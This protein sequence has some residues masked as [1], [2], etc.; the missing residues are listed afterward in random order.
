MLTV[1]LSEGSFSPLACSMSLEAVTN[2]YKYLSGDAMR[3]L[4]ISR[5]APA[6]RLW[7]HT[8]A[9]A[10]LN[11]QDTLH[12]GHLMII[13]KKYQSSPLFLASKKQACNFSQGF[14]VVFGFFLF[15]C[16]FLLGFFGWFFWVFLQ[17][18]TVLQDLFTLCNFYSVIDKNI[19]FTCCKV[20]KSVYDVQQKDVHRLVAF[21]HPGHKGSHSNPDWLLNAYF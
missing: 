9:Q 11:V 15:V 18:A 20:A 3:I 8:S 14:T 19:C 4:A 10:N 6:V 7:I 5:A 21:T 12:S 16:L 1:L 2:I 13:P 17:S